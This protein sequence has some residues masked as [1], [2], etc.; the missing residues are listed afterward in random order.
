MFVKKYYVKKEHRTH[1]KY[2]LIEKGDI[3]KWIGDYYDGYD[4]EKEEFITKRISGI[5]K[6]K[7]FLQDGDLSWMILDNKKMFVIKKI[8]NNIYPDGWEKIN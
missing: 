5:N 2:G 4:E 6:V 7:S 3:I 1:P 8:R